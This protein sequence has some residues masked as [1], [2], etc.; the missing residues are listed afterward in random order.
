MAQLPLLVQDGFSMGLRAPD[1]FIQSALS[2]RVVC[3][4]PSTVT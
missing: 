3:Q 1:S 2:R 4:T